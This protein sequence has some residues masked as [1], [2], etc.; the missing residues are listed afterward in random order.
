MTVGTRVEDDRYSAESYYIT[1][2]QGWRTSL[3]FSLTG[4]YFSKSWNGGDQPGAPHYNRF[5]LYRADQ[6]RTLHYKQRADVPKRLK[7]DD[8]PYT[9]SI[10]FYRDQPVAW[11]RYEYGK[12]VEQD[13][14][15]SKDLWSYG[16]IS[17]NSYEWNNN[18]ILALQGRLR[19]KIAGSDFNMGVFLGEGRQTL[20][21]MTDS[22]TRIFKAMSAVKRGNVLAA[23]DALRTKRPAKLHKSAADNWIELQYGWKPLVQDVFGAA[24]FLAKTLEF[25]MI[26]TYRVTMKKPIRV[27]AIN[28][29]KFS[30]FDGTGVTRCQLIARLSE[31]NVPQL[32]GLLDPASVA[33]EL[34]PWSFVADWFIPIGSYLASR[35][36]AQAL[37]GTFVTTTT[38]RIFCNYSGLPDT[39]NGIVKIIYTRQPGGNY[40]SVDMTRTVSSS[41]NVP[42]PNFKTLDKVA[43][44]QHCANAVAL[45]TQRFAGRPTTAVPTVKPAKFFNWNSVNSAQFMSNS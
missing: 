36:L 6:G 34:L 17:D 27:T 45:L 10:L 37:T 38:R 40:R 31:V 30:S 44:W 12:L 8:H 39:N 4:A 14:R 24:Q 9:C 18:D 2:P 22:A 25:P 3:G 23:A 35:S 32:V 16:W 1:Q 19:E 11:D 20:H 41:L 28:G 33:W 5:S 26:Q 15:M 43:S 21:M 42:L 13:Q 29:T 7:K